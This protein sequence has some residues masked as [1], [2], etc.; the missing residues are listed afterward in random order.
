MGIVNQQAV[1][2]SRK[3]VTGTDA[4]LLNS[5]G[6]ILGRVETYTSQVQ[7]SVAT[8]QPLGDPQQHDV[9]TGYKVTLN[10]TEIMVEDEEMID[11]LFL[12]INE[13]RRPE[14]NFQ[15]VVKGQNG[16]EQRYIYN[17]CVPS[18]NIDLQNITVGDVIKRNWNLTVNGSVKAQGKLKQK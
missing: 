17:Y 1:E 9:P 6:K 4:C 15:G 8:Y 18:G 7:P 14:W 16:G 10:F 2:D 13:G 5:N 3:V 12:F 11:D